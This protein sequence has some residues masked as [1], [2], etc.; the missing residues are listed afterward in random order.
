MT[1]VP[2]EVERARAAVWASAV[3]PNAAMLRPVRRPVPL[4]RFLALL[5]PFRGQHTVRPV[6]RWGAG[7]GR[8]GAREALGAARS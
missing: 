6:R 5:P 8:W 1:R 3:P 2:G 4:S 7:G